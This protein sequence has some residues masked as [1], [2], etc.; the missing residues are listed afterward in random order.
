MQ[1]KI[2]PSQIVLELRDEGLYAWC[3]SRGDMTVPWSKSIRTREAAADHFLSVIAA[4]SNHARLK[5]Y[6]S[7]G[8]I[9]E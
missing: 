1:I 2:D 7:I 6:E 3:W 8:G 9:P 4:M 5:F